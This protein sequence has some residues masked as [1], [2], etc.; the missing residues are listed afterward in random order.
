LVDSCT[1]RPMCPL[2]GGS[3]LGNTSCA[4]K[5]DA[6]ASANTAAAKQHTSTNLQ[7]F[8]KRSPFKAYPRQTG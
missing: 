2:K 4:L 3:G 5:K 6:P 1:V 7:F 8:M